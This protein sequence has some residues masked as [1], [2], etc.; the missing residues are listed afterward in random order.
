MVKFHRRVTPGAAR[1]EPHLRHEKD[2]RVANV[3]AFLLLRNYRIPKPAVLSEAAISTVWAGHILLRNATGAEKA[4]LLFSGG[5]LLLIGG[6]VWDWFLPINKKIWTSSYVLFTGGLA[7]SVLALCYVVIDV[8][9][10]SEWARPFVMYGMN[11][12][13]IYVLSEGFARLLYAIPVQVDGQMQSLRSVVYGALF[14]WVVPA[15]RASLLFALTWVA[16]FLV[17]AWWMY[18][19]KIFLK[20]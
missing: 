16:L 13:A 12:I 11:A 4:T 9:K 8:R 20:V 18:R 2:A 10:R 3:S 17:I 15:E 7:T 5:L 14:G 1:T 6:Y 19:R